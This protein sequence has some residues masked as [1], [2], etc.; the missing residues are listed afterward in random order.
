MS[1]VGAE[2]AWRQHSPPEL[3]SGHVCALATA[4]DQLHH[5]R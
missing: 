5:V 4:G 1:G 3:D 2:R